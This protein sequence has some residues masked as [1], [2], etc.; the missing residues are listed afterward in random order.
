MQKNTQHFVFFNTGTALLA[1]SA[2][3]RAIKR[4]TQS[5]NSTAKII[6][7]SD[8][9]VAGLGALK[10]SVTASISTVI[11]SNIATIFNETE[12]ITRYQCTAQANT[13]IGTVDANNVYGDPYLAIQDSQG[14]VGFGFYPRLPY[15]FNMY[16][17]N[18]RHVLLGS[19]STTKMYSI[20]GIEQTINIGNFKFR[21]PDGTAGDFTPSGSISAYTGNP[22]E[23][24]YNFDSFSTSGTLQD[25]VGA[26]N[27]LKAKATTNILSTH[28]KNRVN[29]VTFISPL[30]IRGKTIRINTPVIVATGIVSQVVHNFDIDNGTATTNIA[31]ALSSSKTIGLASSAGALPDALTSA[32]I[33]TSPIVTGYYITLGNHY[34]TGPVDPGWLGHITPTFPYTDTEHK[35]V[36]QFPELPDT[37]TNNADNV[38]QGPTL[39]VQVPQDELQLFA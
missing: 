31:I 3:A 34:H 26:L 35:F 14:N 6:V 30:V 18:A 16:A 1:I 32:V 15:S 27:T 2:R 11:D 21:I 12:S 24:V 9:S 29:F 7:Q 13:P 38:I 37:N 17:D 10:D 20:N 22:G 28:R 25:K 5:I 33:P 23:Y 39:N 19:S 36:A 4:F 8:A